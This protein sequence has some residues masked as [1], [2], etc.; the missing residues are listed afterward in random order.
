MGQNFYSSEELD[1][2]LAEMKV[3]QRRDMLLRIDEILTAL[4]AASPAVDHWKAARRT[5]Q[6]CEENK[7]AAMAGAPTGAAHGELARG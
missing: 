6:R 2:I 7:F 5:I 3:H 4:D 1:F